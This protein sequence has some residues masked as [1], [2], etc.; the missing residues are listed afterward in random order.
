MDGE[1][2][3]PRDPHTNTQHTR[4]SGDTEYTRM[5]TVVVYIMILIPVVIVMMPV[6]MPGERDSKEVL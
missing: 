6:M 1:G 4:G 5:R 3:K 2:R